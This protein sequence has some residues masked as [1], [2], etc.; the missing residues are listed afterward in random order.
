MTIKP[1]AIQGADL[2]L[3]GVNLQA[4]ATTIV[5]P[6][7]TQATDYF[8]EEVD[9]YGSDDNQ[10]L[11][12]QEGAITII[13]NA[14]YVYR[15]GG[16]QPSGVYV[17][18]E[19]SVDELDDGN[20][21]EINVEVDGTFTAADKTRAEAS[22]MWATLTP[23]PFVEFNADNWTQI[24]FRPKMRAGEVTNVGG[25]G[26]G[27]VVEREIEFPAGESGD[28]AGTLAL[29]P[30]GSLFIC[31]TDWTDV[32]DINKTF[33][34]EAVR[35]FAASQ[36]GF[37]YNFIELLVADHPGLQ[38]IINTLNAAGVD[39]QTDF[40][41]NGGG[42]FGVAQTISQI[43]FG[44]NGTEIVIG[45]PHRTG[46]DPTTIDNVDVFTVIYTGT[47]H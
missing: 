34:G 38:A 2:T 40:T 37:V 24:P 6:G 3:G 12:S 45:W 10:D 31:T 26:S 23:T 35:D 7:V 13:D 17:P 21:E 33:D 29:N 18:A 19:Y 47:V 20:I 39:Y 30:M 36:S 44:N 27:G 15:S 42:D 41:V 28:A 32:D 11:G 1:F 22:N 43:G 25:G 46:V 4:G 16:A 5:I 8:V 14:E 9:E